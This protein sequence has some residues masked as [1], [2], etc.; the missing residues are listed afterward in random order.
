[1]Q[2]YGMSHQDLLKTIE[3]NQLDPEKTAFIVFFDSQ[4]YNLIQTTTT[5][6]DIDIENMSMAN[7]QAIDQALYYYLKQHNSLILKIDD[8]EK[9]EIYNGS[10]IT[11]PSISHAEKITAFID[12]NQDKALYVSCTAGVSRTGAVIHYLDMMTHNPRKWTSR[13]TV[14]TRNKIVYY[15]RSK[16][17]L[18]NRK[19]DKYLQD[20]LKNHVYTGFVIKKGRFNYGSKRI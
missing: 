9:T 13:A 12:A 20:I 18:P 15:W 5:K 17:Y 4:S 11:A 16:H 10:T 7:A 19:L 2:Y 3:L 8:V 1:M 14:D 6:P